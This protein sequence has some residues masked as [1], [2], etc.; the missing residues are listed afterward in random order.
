M[1]VKRFSASMFINK[2]R[3]FF[4]TEG[5]GDGPAKR[6]RSSQADKGAMLPMI[7]YYS[8]KSGEVTK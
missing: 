4:L 1:S 7:Q 2:F 6:T 3:V 8:K 5:R